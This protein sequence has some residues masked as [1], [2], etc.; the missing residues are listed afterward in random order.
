LCVTKSLYELILVLWA[1][2]IA[3]HFFHVNSTN[4]IVIWENFIKLSIA[5][6]LNCNL[7]WR[8]A[9]WGLKILHKIPFTIKWTICVEALHGFVIIIFIFTYQLWSIRCNFWIVNLCWIWT[10]YFIFYLIRST[11]TFLCIGTCFSSRFWWN[12][13]SIA[14]DH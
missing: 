13:L 1:T 14:Y 9:S 2:I 3:P 6:S 10:W 11:L 7:V 4:R 8:A 5:M 12:W